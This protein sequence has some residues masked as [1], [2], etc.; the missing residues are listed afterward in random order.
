MRD[1]KKWFVDLFERLADAEKTC[2]DRVDRCF[3]RMEQKHSE[4]LAL[5]A[6]LAKESETWE[7]HTMKQL[8][9]YEESSQASQLSSKLSL[10]TRHLSLVSVG[11][12]IVEKL[13]DHLE[14]I[15]GGF[16]GIKQCVVTNFEDKISKALK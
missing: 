2:L 12:D 6:T 9:R 8:K 5:S 16:D 4:K 13:K 1:I 15:K 14:E 7:A 11:Q 3:R 10:L